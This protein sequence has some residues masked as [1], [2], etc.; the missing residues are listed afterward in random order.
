MNFRLFNTLVA[1]RKELSMEK[2]FIIF[3]IF[4]GFPKKVFKATVIFLQIVTSERD[5]R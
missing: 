1:V 5:L 3:R 4:I 2:V